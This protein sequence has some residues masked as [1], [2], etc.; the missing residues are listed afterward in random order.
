[1]Q[2]KVT[3]LPDFFSHKINIGQNVRTQFL[4]NR[5]HLLN[6]YITETN[7]FLALLC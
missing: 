3:Y 6:E 7:M 5:S 1:M 4:F 2:E